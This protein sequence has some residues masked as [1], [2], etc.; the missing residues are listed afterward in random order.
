MAQL[1]ACGYN[2]VDKLNVNGGFDPSKIEPDK[3]LAIDEEG[4]I[5]VGIYGKYYGQAPQ[6]TTVLLSMGVNYPC[7]EVEWKSLD[8]LDD[9]GRR[10]ILDTVEEKAT[11]KFRDNEGLG[12]IINSE[13]TNCLLATNSKNLSIDAFNSLDRITFE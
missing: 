3:F 4:R 1:L 10:Y 8:D 9:E 2:F 13:K 12:I 7:G 5:L 11:A 6:G